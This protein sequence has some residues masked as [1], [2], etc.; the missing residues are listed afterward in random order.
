M[1]ACDLGEVSDSNTGKKV[2]HSRSSKYRTFEIRN[3]RLQSE[4]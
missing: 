3:L 2:G 4:I 1:G